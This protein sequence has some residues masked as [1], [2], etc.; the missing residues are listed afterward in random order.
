MTSDTAVL[1]DVG[2]PLDME[3]AW[4]IAVD[5]AIVA[6]FLPL[7][8]V[9]HEADLADASARAVSAFAPD[10][11]AA[12]ILDL[13]GGDTATASRVE[14]R[15]R[16]ML[17]GLDVFQLRPGMAELLA[18]LDARGLRLGIVANQPTSA[19][20][21]LERA[22]IAGHFRHVGLSGTTGLRK[23]APRIF[24]AAAEA[25]GVP[26]R[27]CIMIGDRIDNDV[28]PAKALGMRTIRFRTGRHARQQPRTAA[29]T[30]DVEVVDTLELAEAIER[31]CADIG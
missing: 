26:P 8:V 15:V 31:A 13:C 16:D 6:A 1:F 20:A 12:M 25:L 21:R 5:S 22:G 3:F 4:E 7:G 24:L 19:L 23:P 18:R 28:A 17:D 27:R 2:G 29:E 10:A 14:R 11:Y 9:L 30:P